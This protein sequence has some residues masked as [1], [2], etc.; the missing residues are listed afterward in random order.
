MRQKMGRP[1]RFIARTYLATRKRSVLHLERPAT[2]AKLHGNGLARNHVNSE[3][4]V[5]EPFTSSQQFLR[6]L[7]LH[8]NAVAGLS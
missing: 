3:I 6:A 5:I 2:V 7:F 1:G 8:P 4:S